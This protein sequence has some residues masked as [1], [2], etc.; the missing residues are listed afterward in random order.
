MLFKIFWLK[1][2]AKKLALLTQNKAKV[3][4]ILII[5]LVLEKNA[6]FFDE[7]CQKSQKTVIITSTPGLP[8]F[9]WCKHAKTGK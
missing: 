3:R 8:D 1:N 7:I 2:S 9:S 4:K 6:K 5:T